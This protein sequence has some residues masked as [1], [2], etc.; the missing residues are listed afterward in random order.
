[1]LWKLASLGYLW[2]FLGDSCQTC[3]SYS[4]D[5]LQ[6]SHQKALQDTWM[7]IQETGFKSLLWNFSPFTTVTPCEHGT[8]FLWHTHTLHTAV[9]TAKKY[10]AGIDYHAYA[11]AVD[12]AESGLFD[13]SVW[14]SFW[15]Q[16]LDESWALCFPVLQHAWFTAL[17]KLFA[18][19]PFV[20]QWWDVLWQGLSLKTTRWLRLCLM[21]L[22]AM[23]NCYQCAL[24]R[25][26]LKLESLP[27]F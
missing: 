17:T 14:V 1:M 16:I 25:P 23:R 19:V 8:P 3:C 18:V 6:L 9:H 20:R 13:Y 7:K 4:L 2:N 10:T 22:S 5:G 21:T 15:R 11:V 27:E 26:L 24:I 12:K